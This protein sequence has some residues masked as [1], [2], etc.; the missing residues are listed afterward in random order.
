M[1]LEAL[2]M[3][4]SPEFWRM[5]VMWTLSLLYSYLLLFLRGQTATPRR[6]RDAVDR[7]ICV[8]TGVS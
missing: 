6:R 7:P 3:V 1:D 4:C 5:G 2:R 8:V